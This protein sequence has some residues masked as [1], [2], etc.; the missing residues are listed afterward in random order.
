[1]NTVIN[2]A[3]LDID[4]FFVAGAYRALSDYFSE[5]GIE[6]RCSDPMNA[7]LVFQA[8]AKGD[9]ARFCHPP[10]A[11]HA[12]YLAV[13]DLREARIR[14][15]SGCLREAGRVYR[16]EG[17]AKLLHTVARVIKGRTGGACSFSCCAWCQ[18]LPLTPQEKQVMRYL[19]WEMTPTAIARRLRVSIKTVSTHKRAVMRK[20]HFQRDAELYRWL[21]LGG[22]GQGNGDSHVV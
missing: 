17:V 12:L 7:D 18:P 19:S 6:A 11:P 2:I 16:N 4:R 22:F 10:H 9:M 5:R 8:I 1:M 20:M 14:A 15:I 3:F 21:R 13:Y